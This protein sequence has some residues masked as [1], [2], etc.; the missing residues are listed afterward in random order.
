MTRPQ[1]AELRDFKKIALE[2]QEQHGG[3]FPREAEM[4]GR[5]FL[6]TGNDDVKEA[7][8]A[9][10]EA[11]PISVDNVRA[12]LGSIESSASAP[13]MTSLMKSKLV[14]ACSEAEYAP[15]CVSF[16]KHSMSAGGENLQKAFARNSLEITNP[17][18]ARVLA[19]VERQQSPRSLKRLYLRLN[20][21]EYE[22]MQ[23]RG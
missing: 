12:C 21:E 22:R 7:A 17:F 11:A 18:T 23:R 9:L 3:V 14:A 5:Y 16:I 20:R 19:Q 2:W 8:L 6:S 10:M 4:V 13:L 15:M 1:A